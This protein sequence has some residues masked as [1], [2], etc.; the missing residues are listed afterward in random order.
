MFDT[1][2]GLPLHPLVV[3]AVVVLLPL[4]AVVTIAVAARP[5]WR[6]FALPVLVADVVTLVLAF[7]AKESGEKL[8][9]RLEALRGNGA[10][11]AQEHAE[12]GELVPLFA[13]GLVVAAFVVYFGRRKPGL[14]AVGTV[15]SVIAGIAVVAWTIVVGHSGATDVW[16][17]VVSGS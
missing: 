5:A 10:K 12:Q 13:L 14:A 15:L 8:Q 2:T 16:S 11:V 9:V 17:S 7:V 3:H 1:V 6:G 4:M